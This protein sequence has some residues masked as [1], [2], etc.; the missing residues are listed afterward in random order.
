MIDKYGADAMRL[1]MLGSP[2]VRAES[3]AFSEKEVGELSRKIFGR[4]ANVY[5][6]YA[7]YRGESQVEMV[8]EPKANL[9]KWIVNRLVETLKDVTIGLDAYQLDV[10]ARPI[11]RFVDDLST[12]YLR[13]SRETIKNA[14]DGDRSVAVLGFV[15]METAKMLAPFAPFFADWLWQNL[16]RADWVESVHLMNWNQEL[17][18]HPIDSK[19][20]QDMQEVRNVVSLALEQRAKAGIPVRQPLSRLAMVS[21]GNTFSEDLLQLIKDEVNVKEIARIAGLSE[22]FA[23]ELDMAITPE[24][25]EE[26]LVREV[27][28]VLQQARKQKDLNPGEWTTGTV[29]ISDEYLMQVVKKN[30][31]TIRGAT[32]LSKL[33]LELGEERL[34]VR[35]D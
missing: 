8:G 11:D 18:T 2:V 33:T 31:E 10:A 13:R 9:D 4:L 5:E 15:L 16:R 23:V 26:G 24:L 29:S 17:L 22:G 35:L 14:H 12:W 30:I 19:S 28:R 20:L 3:L 27:I 6:F 32:S 7:L 1:Y 34:T 25:R 21:G